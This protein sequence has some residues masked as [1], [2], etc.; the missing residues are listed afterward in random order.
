MHPTPLRDYA[1][2]LL[3]LSTSQCGLKISKAKIVSND[4]MPVTCLQHPVIAIQTHPFVQFEIPSDHHPTFARR[5]GLGCLKTVGPDSAHR[6][7]QTS[8][9]A[10]CQCLSGIFNNP[11]TAL[12]CQGN[13]LVHCTDVPVGVCWDDHFSPSG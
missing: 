5:N 12:T 7:S 2:N 11:Y 6:A 3:K 8:F 9:I 13:D 10:G 4:F 1:V